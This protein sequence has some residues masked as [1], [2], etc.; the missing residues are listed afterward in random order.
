MVSIMRMAEMLYLSMQIQMVSRSGTFFL[1]S[2]VVKCDCVHSFSSS[3]IFSCRIPSLACCVAMRKEFVN[4]CCLFYESGS[5]LGLQVK[6]WW[7]SCKEA[8]YSH[9]L[10][11][12]NH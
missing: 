2:N 11:D 7:P 6:K 5:R 1:T 8:A 10:H 4:R 12:G 3:S 9:I